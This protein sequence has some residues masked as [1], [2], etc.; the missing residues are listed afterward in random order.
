MLNEIDRPAPRDRRR[1]RRPRHRQSQRPVAGTA[2]DG[3]RQQ[4]RTTCSAT[5]RRGAARRQV[6]RD[7]GAREAAGTS[8]CARARATGRSRPRTSSAPRAPPKAGPPRDVADALDA[9]A[10]VVEPGGAGAGDVLAGRGARP[11]REGASDLAWEVPQARPTAADRRRRSH[12]RSPR[13]RSYG[14]KL[15]NGPVARDPQAVVTS[16]QVTFDAAGGRSACPR[17]RRERDR[18]PARHRRGQL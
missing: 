12:R 6:P 8:K 3:A 11:G 18:E 1:D 17:H 16:G 9:L 7:P 13:R 10:A 5:P 14:D 15:F 4:R 2:A